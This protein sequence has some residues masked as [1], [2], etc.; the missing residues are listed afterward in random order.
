MKDLQ[1]G[2]VLS[3]RIRFNNSGDIS[4]KKHPYLIISIDDDYNT[5]EI[6][7]ID[8]I[9]PNKRFKAAMRSNKVIFKDNPL[10]SVIDKD[11]FVQLDNTF[12][13]E[14]F[15]TL[16]VYRRQPNVLSE[17]K[18]NEVL[19]AYKEY[20]EMYSIDENKNVYMDE[21][22]INLLNT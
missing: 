12:K 5:V 16:S 18:L 14:Y 7:Q 9:T 15:D 17:A 20:H 10:E 3:L 22:E 8:S 4:S 21:C 11:S 19:S 6:A 1:I 2:Q 13:V